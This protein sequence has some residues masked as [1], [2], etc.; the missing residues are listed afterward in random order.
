MVPLNITQVTSIHILDVHM[1]LVCLN[2]KYIH[3]RI[4][5]CVFVCLNVKYIGQLA[6]SRP[7]R[8]VLLSVCR[9]LELVSFR[10][11]DV[12]VKRSPLKKDCWQQL[13]SVV[14]LLDSFVFV[15]LFVQ[16]CVL[17]LCA[18]LCVYMFP[19][20]VSD[21]SWFRSTSGNEHSHIRRA[22]VYLSI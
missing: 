13:L 9:R 5:I 2:L 19:D 17:S 21:G 7:I 11:I 6:V 16:I 22:H 3:T 10:V 15:C 20:V 18:L 1:C 4:Y 14:L 12:L 8:L